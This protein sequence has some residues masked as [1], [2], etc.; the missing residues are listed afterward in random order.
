M[1]DRA[2]IK[3]K[4]DQ[5]NNSIYVYTHWYGHEW[6]EMLQAALK[7]GEGRWN[8]SQY[9]QR[10]IITELCKKANDPTGFGVTTW[11]GD[12]EHDIMEVD[13]KEKKVRRLSRDGWHDES[14]EW[15]S[16]PPRVIQELT[17]AE[18]C[19]AKLTDDDD[20]E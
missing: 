7:A 20:E 18:Y 10:F 15:E 5:G 8:D 1:G 16:L 3:I 19:S 6:P 2:N 14:K 17:F 4:E 11:R 13:M 12:N 9:L